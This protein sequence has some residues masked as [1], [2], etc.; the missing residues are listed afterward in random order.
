MWNA[1]FETGG[2][3]YTADDMLGKGDRDARKRQ[4]LMDQATTVKVRVQASTVK[5]PPEWVRE[6]ER[7]QREWKN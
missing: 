5:E 3:P 7:N 1:H 6:I 2:V 4:H